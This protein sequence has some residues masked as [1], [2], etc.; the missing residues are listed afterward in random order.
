MYKYC[1]HGDV[2]RKAENV[3]WSQTTTL[4]FISKI[5]IKFV[6]V[7]SL[8]VKVLEQHF[9]Y[10]REYKPRCFNVVDPLSG[11][12]LRNNIFVHVFDID[13]LRHQDAKLNTLLDF[14]TPIL[15]FRK[16]DVNVSMNVFV[17]LARGECSSMCINEHLVIRRHDFFQSILVR[18][19]H[20]S[21]FLD[22]IFF[23]NWF[24]KMTFGGIK[25][26]LQC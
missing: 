18:H 23:H 4:W 16:M 2:F 26:Q 1:K 19:V 10:K 20:D 17:M 6:K 12:L 9:T 13:P 15:S 7:P 14:I 25:I 24:W 3:S 22:Q 5:T 21:W 11:N 8:M